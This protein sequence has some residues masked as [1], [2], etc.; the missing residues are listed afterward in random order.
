MGNLLRKSRGRTPGLSGKQGEGSRCLPLCMGGR[1]LKLE[2]LGDA[3][4]LSSFLTLDNRYGNR[5]GNC[6]T[7][8]LAGLSGTLQ[9]CAGTGHN[10]M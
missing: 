9:I 7:K 3:L 5:Q 2:C 8:P 6:C 1:R 10:S 4:S